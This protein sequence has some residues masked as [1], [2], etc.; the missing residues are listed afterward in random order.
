MS[1]ETELKLYIDPKY[2]KQF[3][4]HPFLQNKNYI[5]QD[6]YS[7]YYDTVKH[8][9]LRNGVGLRVRRVG[10][11]WIQTMKTANKA[12]DGLHQRQ[13][14]EM[15][16]NSEIP[17]YDKFPVLP[18][19]TTNFQRMKWDLVFDDG[20][21]IELVLDQG[22]VKANNASV[23]LSEVEL[24]L[25]AGSVDKLFE[26]A[27]ILQQQVPLVIKNDSKAAMGYALL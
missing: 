4:D 10:D 2:I 6:L 26:V 5:T 1:I 8:D 7:I 3:L 24:E 12:V 15:E 14:W 13:E 17:E 11:K 19:F 21:E 16:I 9:L 22:E 23:P 25:K 20:S 27:D 18:L